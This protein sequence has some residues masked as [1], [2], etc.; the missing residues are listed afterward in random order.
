MAGTWQQELMPRPWR[1]VAYWLAFHGWFRLPYRT[2]DQK[3]KD[4]TTHHGL[5]PPP[6][7]TKSENALQVD[8]KEAF[9]QLLP[10]MT[11]QLVSS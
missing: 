3:L 9:S 4:G 6:L 7:I 10:L 1:R 2:Q 5:D 8:F 11:L